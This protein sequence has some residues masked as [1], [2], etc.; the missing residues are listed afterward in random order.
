MSKKPKNRMRPIHPGEILREEY[1]APLELSANR[2]GDALG[3]PT[4]RVTE[5]L[6]GKRSVTAETALRLARALQTTPEFWMNLQ[7]AYELRLAESELGDALR[8]IKPLARVG[9]ASID[10]PRKKRR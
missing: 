9:A 10:P 2:F 4:N 5:T 1:L 6:K 8:T 3:V 7:Q